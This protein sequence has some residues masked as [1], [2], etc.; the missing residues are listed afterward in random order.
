MSLDIVKNRDGG[1]LDVVLNGRLD[2]NTSPDLEAVVKQD[3]DGVTKLVLDMA[4][5]EYISSAGLRVVLAAHKAMSKQGDLIVRGPSEFI[6]NVFELTGF[7]E[8]L[9]IEDSAA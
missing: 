2:T 4:G 8:I 7:L 9:T 6:M 1:T 3:L 5:L